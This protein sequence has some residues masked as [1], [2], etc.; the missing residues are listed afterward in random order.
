[1]LPWK[2]GYFG[3]VTDC[4][5]SYYLRGESP[6]LFIPLKVF[7]NSAFEIGLVFFII[8]DGS[9]VTRQRYSVGDLTT[10]AQYA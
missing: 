8:G 3:E 9:F 1:M 7:H 10:H 4:F 2:N 6:F 5:A